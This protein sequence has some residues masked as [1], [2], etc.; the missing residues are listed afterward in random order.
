VVGEVKSKFRPG[1][2]VLQLMLG[3]ISASGRAE[4]ALAAARPTDRDQPAPAGRAGQT[5]PLIALALGL[6]SAR[7]S[8]LQAVEPLRK[9]K[10]RP[11]PASPRPRRR[12]PGSLLR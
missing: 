10:R 7:G 9:A 2:L 12:A 6:L 5:D 3:L 1:N 4:K 8:L 11:S